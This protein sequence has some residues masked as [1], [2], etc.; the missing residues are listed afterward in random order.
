MERNNTQAKYDDLMRKFME[1]KVSQGPG[2]GAEGRARFTIIDPARLPE[3]PY[4]PNRLAIMLIGLVLGVGA[5]GRPGASTP[6][7]RCTTPRP[8]GLRFP[9]LATIPVSQRIRKIGR[10]V[11]V[12]W[13]WR[14][15]Q[16]RPRSRGWSCFTSRS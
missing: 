15:V 14:A 1:S 7:P 6:T 9:V 11:R 5:R 4:K 3:K 10:T 2:K 16:R 8:R 12:C 13:R